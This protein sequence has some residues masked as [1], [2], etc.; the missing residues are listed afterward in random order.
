MKHIIFVVW[1]F[2]ILLQAVPAAAAISVYS[3]DAVITDSSTM[4]RVAF[5][6]TSPVPNLIFSIPG[7]PQNVNVFPST[8]A[9]DS[10]LLQTNIICNYPMSN[11][12]VEYTSTERISRK[13]IWGGFVWSDSFSIPEPV[14]NLNVNIQIPAGA[15]LKEPI[16][17][18]IT[19]QDATKSSDGRHILI[20]W[21]ER[22]VNDRWSASIAYERIEIAAVLPT[23]LAI[24]AIIAAVGV[25]TYRHYFRS[26]KDGM[27]MIL[28]I[29][30][31]DEKAV[32]DALLKHGSGVN[33]KVIVKESGYSKAKVSK[34]LKSLVERH[35]V[36]LERTGRS[37]RIF[38]GRELKKE[39]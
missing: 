24:I 15:A 9:I 32:L 22:D 26:E 39:S 30:K 14:A 31:K 17:D 2:L 37:N 35:I 38:W 21:S 34:V 19:P 29:L 16:S 28:P 33:Q 4:Y 6:F 10:A 13:T 27:K 1:I 5:N 18:A 3:V 36:K 25:I 20:S 8:C 7:S 12:E 11:F 23:I